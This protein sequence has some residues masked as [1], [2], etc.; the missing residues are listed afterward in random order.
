MTP[1]DSDTQASQA[2]PESPAAAAFPIVGIGASAGGLEALEAMTRRLTADGMAFVVL[3]HLAPGHDS[4]LTDILARNT[5]MPVATVTDGMPVEVDHIYVTPPNAELAIHQRVLRLMPPDPARRGP[6]PNIDAFLRTLAA[7]LGKLAIGVILSGAGSDG[8][9]GL[10]AIKEEG[11]VTFVQDPA[12]ASQP[13]MPQSALDAGVADFALRA[14]EIGDEL[15][16]LSTHPYVAARPQKRFDEDTRSKL[17]ILLRSAF[18][19]DFGVYKPTTI[20]RRIQRRLM[21]HKLDRLEDYLSYVQANAAELNLLY[22]D[23][24]IGVTAFFRDKEPFEALTSVVFPRLFDSRRPDV[25]LRVW[26]AGCSTG[27]EAYSIAICLL[28]YLGDRSPGYK[29]QIFATDV[30]DQAL[31]QARTAIYPESI[32]LDVSP[33]RLQRFFAR[34]DKGFQVNRAIRDMVVFAH[35]NLGKDPPFSHIDLVSCRNV[36][37]YMQPPLQKKV[38]RVLHYALG[39]D[40]FLLLGTSESVGEASDLFT[41]VDRKNKLYTKKNVVGPAAFDVA[42][43][44]RTDAEPAK[45][46]PAEHRS[47][48]SLLQLADRKVIEQYGPPGVV[49][50]EAFDVLQYRGKTGRFFEPTPGAATINLLKLIRPELLHELR[51]A[52]P[53]ALHEGVRVVSDPVQLGHDADASTVRLDVMP[54]PDPGGA[55][56]TLLVLFTEHGPGAALEAPAAAGAVL[57]GRAGRGAGARAGG[58]QGVPPGDDRGAG[59]RQRGAPELQRGAPELQR[60]APEHQRGAGDLQGGAAIDQRGAGHASTRSCRAAWSSSA[61]PTTICRTSSAPAPSRWCWSAP[62]SGSGGSRPRPRSC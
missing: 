8:T 51:T 1:H 40:A 22:S 23:L 33:Q 28:E 6:R 15:A 59:G 57:D 2:A 60:G 50:S 45:L 47:G 27:E 16:R 34:S 42:I 18:G 43:G 14:E 4:I 19:V 17:F 41:L 56:T 20:E 9:L 25:P 52:L 29:V 31:A 61:S 11:G 58:H 21:L 48:V 35:H 37:I 10:K 46:R 30:D 54:L 26:V 12:T 39:P 3:Q 55:G 5:A 24:L 44:A 62:T 36:L 53:R 7:D 38:L 49:V 32:D 13:S